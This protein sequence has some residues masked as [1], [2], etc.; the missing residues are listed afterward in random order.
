MLVNNLI[1]RYIYITNLSQ[2]KKN[3]LFLTLLLALSFGNILT[4]KAQVVSMNTQVLGTGYTGS[5]GQTGI[6]FVIENTNPYPAILT[7]VSNYFSSAITSGFTLHYSATSL[8]GSPGAML[9][10]TWT[11]A[12]SSASV[13]CAGATQTSLFTGLNFT[14]PANTTY[15]FVLAPE[16]IGAIAYLSKNGQ[17]LKEKLQAGWVLACCGDSGKIHYKNSRRG[18]ALVDRISK[19]ILNQ[20]PLEWTDLEFSVGGSDERQFCSPGYNLPLGSFMRTPYQR[21]PQYHTSLD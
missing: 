19:H 15:R 5:N 16:T 9:A 21:Y 7:G 17:A 18:D 3:L 8:S 1:I 4:L 11:L 20:L 13:A 2:M 10:P 14:I 6:T 12:A